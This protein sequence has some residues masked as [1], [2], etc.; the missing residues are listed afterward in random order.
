MDDEEK[1]HSIV[2]GVKV[3]IRRYVP[4]SEDAIQ[5]DK[6]GIPIECQLCG[7]EYEEDEEDDGT[8]I[9]HTEL[10]QMIVMVEQKVMVAENII[11]TDYIPFPYILLYCRH[12]LEAHFKA[13]TRPEDLIYIQ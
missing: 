8:V 11:S 12:C 6:M 10:V 1:F 3:L 4:G 9:T 7:Q 5:L 13:P 2:R